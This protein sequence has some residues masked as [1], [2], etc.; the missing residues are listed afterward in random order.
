MRA[1]MVEGGTG[2]LKL[3]EA[4][5][6]APGAGDVLVKVRAAS[7]NRGEFLHNAA[8]PGELKPA[9]MEAAGVVEAVGANVTHV[10]P[11]DAVMGRAK[12]GGFAD[13]ALMAKEEVV[14]KPDALSFEEA[15]GASI[16]YWV[17]YDM[18]VE[19]GALQSGQH[20]LVTGISSGV[21][22]ACLQIAKQVGATVL[23]TSGSA[24]KLARLQA[25]GLDHG[26][27]AR[28]GGFAEQVKK[29]TGSGVH[30]AVNN[31]GGSALPDLIESLA[32]RGRLAIVGHVDHQLSATLSLERVHAQRLM[33]FGVSNRHRS[34]PERERTVN[35][36]VRDVVPHL[37]A[38][39]IKP[40]VDARIP[41]A[42]ADAGRELMLSGG[43]LGKIVLLLD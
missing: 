43:H 22:V 42:N 25:L 18:L 21:G 38:G 20:L 33:I 2:H 39:R 31:V 26:I 23:G 1:W 12:A 27:E 32:Y 35:G 28:G 34:L 5:K 15:A 13:Y 6:P 24:Q 10:K 14:V 37:A 4:P 40:P 29:L 19:G 7:Y 30:L 8:K 36:F 41:F 17:A 3:T 9:G 11:G 16:A